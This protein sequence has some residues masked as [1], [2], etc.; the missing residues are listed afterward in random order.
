M[1]KLLR[2]FRHQ[3][4]A[5]QEDTSAAHIIMIN[6]IIWQRQRPGHKP[7]SKAADILNKTANNFNKTADILNN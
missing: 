3:S 5:L 6:G 7:R 4:Q 2:S 1:V